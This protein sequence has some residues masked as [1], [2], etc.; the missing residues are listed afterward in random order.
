MFQD[1]L[2]KIEAAVDAHA[3]LTRQFED[4]QDCH[5]KIVIE[6]DRCRAEISIRNLNAS[7]PSAGSMRTVYGI[8]ST[9]DKAATALITSLITWPSWLS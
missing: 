3:F 7:G 5:A 6:H 2:K 4:G 9:P 8:G 1:L